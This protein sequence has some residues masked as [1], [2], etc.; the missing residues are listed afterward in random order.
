M[1]FAKRTKEQAVPRH[2]EDNPRR[3]IDGGKR[4]GKKAQE[5]A[6][7]DECAEKI[8]PIAFARKLS[9]AS[10]FFERGGEP[11]KPSMTT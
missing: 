3:R 1:S 6:N 2:R 7:V 9:G 4:A 10:V 11:S 5:N 8:P